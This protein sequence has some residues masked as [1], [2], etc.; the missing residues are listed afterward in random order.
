M[1]QNFDTE[2][3]KKL[4]PVIELGRSQVLTK[5]RNGL[6]ETVVVAKESGSTKLMTTAQNAL[7]GTKA[8]SKAFES[9]FDC[10]D[11]YAEYLKRLEAA[12]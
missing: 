11:R 6:E 1:N 8:I 5:L 10:A 9:L 7:E 4:Q 3:A 2:V 12:L